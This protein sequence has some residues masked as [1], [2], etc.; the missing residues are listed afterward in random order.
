M[1]PPP[2][3]MRANASVA[4]AQGQFDAAVADQSVVEVHLGDSDGKV[5]ADGE[6]RATSEQSD[7]HKQAAEELGKR[8]EIPG[9]RRQSEA[10]DELGMVVKSAENFVVS[11]IE[12]DG[13]QGEAHDE[14]REG[15]QAIE[16]AQ[17]GSSCE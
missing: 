10:G 16:V 7:E 3:K 11:V 14:E 13:A 9:P 6:C 15:L 2:K 8:G 12:H 5:D 4:S 1:G 17:V